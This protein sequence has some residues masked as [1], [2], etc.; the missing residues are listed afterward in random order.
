MQRKGSWKR[1]EKRGKKCLSN[2][3][4]EKA[5]LRQSGDTVT[6]ERTSNTGLPKVGSPP[7]SRSASSW[8]TFFI[9]TSSNAGV[10]TDGVL[11]SGPP[12]K[13]QDRPGRTAPALA[14]D[15]AIRVERSFEPARAFEAEL[16]A[17]HQA[18]P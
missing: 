13:T 17:A 7:P 9:R 3:D 15:N 4:R 6:Q 1:D 8:Q 14:A 10:R 12:T 5:Q 11:S 18:P 2:G 16:A